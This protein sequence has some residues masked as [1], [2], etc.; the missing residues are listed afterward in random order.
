MFKN[1]EDSIRRKNWDWRENRIK[2]R[3]GQVWKKM[4]S[5]NVGVVTGVTDEMC[6]MQ[7]P[8]KRRNHHIRK[9]DLFMFWKQF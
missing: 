4:D 5:G 3:K 1:A 8:N 7:Q 6:Y 2:V 9:R